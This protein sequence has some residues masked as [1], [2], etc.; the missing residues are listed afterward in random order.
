[1]VVSNLIKME[2]LIAALDRA[3]ISVIR[4]KN[5]ASMEVL[6]AY[7]GVV[8]ERVFF[9]SL[10]PVSLGP[11]FMSIDAM[12]AVEVDIYSNASPLY[13]GAVAVGPANN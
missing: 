1:M 12:R 2:L 4:S 7:L 3:S 9:A 11:V 13:P 5:H 10:G 8:E 6:V